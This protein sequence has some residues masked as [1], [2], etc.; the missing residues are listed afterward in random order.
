MKE[1][2]DR[3][4]IRRSVNIEGTNPGVQIAKSVAEIEQTDPTNLPA[5]YGCVDDVLDNIFS[6]PPDPEAQMQIEFSYTGY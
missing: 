1:E 5:M 3:Q 2:P 6:D 4:I